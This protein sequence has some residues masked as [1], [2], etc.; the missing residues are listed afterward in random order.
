MINAAG[1]QIVPHALPMAALL[2]IEALALDEHA[3]LGSDPHAIYIV[4]VE[5]RRTERFVNGRTLEEIGLLLLA[6][7]Q[8][9]I[10]LR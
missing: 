6:L 3:A 5:L 1:P 8:V 4:A 7:L 9:E 2:C 10:G